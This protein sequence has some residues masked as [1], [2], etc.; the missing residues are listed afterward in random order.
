MSGRRDS[1]SR[2]PAPKAGALTGL[3]YAPQHITIVISAAKIRKKTPTTK[4]CVYN[5][6]R[7]TFICNIIFVKLFGQVP[8]ERYFAPMKFSTL[9]GIALGMFAIF[10]AYILEGGEFETL[11]LMPAMMIV[12]GGTFAAALAG[13]SVGH[14]LRIPKLLS[15]AFFPRRYDTLLIINQIIFL[16]TVSRRDGILGLEKRLDEVHHPFLRKLIESAIDGAS[17]EILLQTAEN[18]M[19]FMTERHNSNIGLFTKMGG[20][21]PTMGIIGTVMGL[22]STLASAGSDPNI[23]IRHIA[24]AFIATMWGILMANIVWLPIGDKLRLLHNEEISLMRVM[25]TGVHSLLLGETPSVIRAKLLSTMP[26]SVQASLMRSA[27]APNPPQ[28]P[29]AMSE[30]V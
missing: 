4:L 23:L 28:P 19:D 2:P 14:I 29:A 16:S 12:F 11:F 25:F 17:P 24:V 21:S 30:S 20:Y 27:S 18:D 7:G 1:N 15:I 22:I 6:G 3:R 13:T 9:L 26:L 5:G 10:G 8:Q